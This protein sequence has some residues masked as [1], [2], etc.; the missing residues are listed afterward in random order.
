MRTCLNVFWCLF[1][2]C[3]SWASVGRAQQQPP[4][5]PTGDPS[6]D[7]S[8]LNPPPAAAPPEQVPQTPPPTPPQTP[9]ATTSAWADAAGPTPPATTP[10]EQAPV[11]QPRIGLRQPPPPLPKVPDIRQP[12][13]TG[14]WINVS[15]WLPTETPTIDKGHAATFTQ[16]SLTKLQGKPKFTQ[17]VEAGIAAG[18]AQCASPLLFRIARGRRFHQRDRSGVLEPTLSRGEPGLHKLQA[19]EY[20]ALLRLPDVALSRGKPYIPAEDA[21]Q[22]QYTSVRT[23]SICRYCARGGLAPAPP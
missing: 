16:A 1:L 14:W 23:A 10:P 18:P 2:L 3:F 19:P 9:P 4:T 12:G 6:A 13:E 15:A 20:Q 17:G 22:I 8:P 21:Y 7:Q 11:A 5:T